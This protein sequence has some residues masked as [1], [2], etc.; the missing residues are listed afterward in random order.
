MKKRAGNCCQT[1]IGGTGLKCGR[2]RRGKVSAKGR[3]KRH[4]STLR[5]AAGIAKNSFPEFQYPSIFFPVAD[6]L[7]LPFPSHS[8]FP[9]SPF[10]ID[11]PPPPF[12]VFT[13]PFQRK[14]LHRYLELSYS[15]SSSCSIREKDPSCSPNRRGKNYVNMIRRIGRICR[16][17]NVDLKR[18][19]LKIIE[20]EFLFA[21]VN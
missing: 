17:Q 20:I 18:T 13:L 19:R 14:I 12:S 7:P 21:S 1:E 4:E 9:S 10:S 11:V 3:M 5:R 6:S 15:S 8:H 2:E 16:G